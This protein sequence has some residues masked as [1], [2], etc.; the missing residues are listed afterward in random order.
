MGGKVAKTTTSSWVGCSVRGNV[1]RDT[2]QQPS[3]TLSTKFFEL[4]RQCTI[5]G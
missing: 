1:D 4:A 2:F 5:E 3:L